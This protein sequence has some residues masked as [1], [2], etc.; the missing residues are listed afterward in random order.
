MPSY[1][2]ANMSHD[3]N[4]S[5]IVPTYKEADNLP[6][7]VPLLAGALAAANLTAEIIVVDDGSPDN[8]RP[9]C[10][11]L[12]RSY[13]LQL[14]VRRGERGLSSAV[15]HGMRLARGK[16]L[17][18]MD[19]DLSHPAEAIPDLVQALDDPTVDFVIGSRYTAGGGTA[20]DW[21]LFRWMNSKVATLLARPLVR[22]SDPMAGFFALR[23]QSF[24]SASNLDPV[25]YKIGLELIVKC[26]CKNI[27]EMPI[28]FRNRLH[29]QS[30][31]TLKEQWN[32]LRHLKR[33]YE[34]RLGRAALPVQFAAVGASGT[35]IDLAAFS[36][37]LLA[38]PLP[39]ARG[40]AI[41]TAMTWNFWLNRRLT[42]SY[43]RHKPILL[44]YILFATASLFG[45]VVSWAT[46]TYLVAQVEFFSSY[47][48]SAAVVGILAGAVLNYLFSWLLAF[49][50]APAKTVSHET[51]S[52]REPVR[53]TPMNSQEVG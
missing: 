27:R 14:E 34:Y 35:L 24:E 37:L 50:R 26:G 5:V 12:A 31:L 13:P 10:E 16:V 2:L 11:E 49:G 33:L 9:V 8:T 22:A 19:A 17:V 23:Q 4:V 42:F 29:G 39:I 36:L 48:L 43:S 21:G 18:V 1:S 46:S 52:Q 6:V 20:E 51:P 38:F 7:L 28:N 15:I 25:G 45:G 41:W 3:V 53:R 30:K 44:Q 32:Y 40:L 47:V